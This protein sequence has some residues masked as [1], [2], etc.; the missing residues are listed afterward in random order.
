MILLLERNVP[1]ISERNADDKLPIHLLCGS[2][3]VDRNSLEYVDAI[4]RLLLAHPQTV[5][6]LSLTDG[7]RSL[8]PKFLPWHLECLIGDVVIHM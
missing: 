5:V 2:D 8:L 7:E 1:S 3:K 6:D 4:W